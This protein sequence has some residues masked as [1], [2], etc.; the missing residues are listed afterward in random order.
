MNNS[1]TFENKEQKL[2]F[3]RLDDLARRADGGAV[4]H[5]AFLTPGE[6]LAAERYFSEKGMKDRICFFGGYRDAQRKQ[7]FLL[8]EY[9]ADSVDISKF[10]ALCEALK[11]DFEE[12]TK[13]IKITGSGFREL[14]HRDYLGSILSL[15]IERSSVGDICILDKSSAL[16]FCV[17][18]VSQLVLSELTSIGRDGVRV[19]EAKLDVNMP[20]TQKYQAFTDTVASERLDCVIASL[21]NLSRERAQNLIRAGLVEFNYE[22]AQK[23]DVKCAADDIISARGYGKF[24]IRSISEQTRK[25]RLRLLADKYV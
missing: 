8:P 1:N 9:L 14:T 25:G 16:I 15:G 19:T 7:I 11:E 10:D 4:A 12:A 6:V 18:S 3:A 13:A 23:T 5:S 24:V 21:C 22:T 20:S 17:E 2:F